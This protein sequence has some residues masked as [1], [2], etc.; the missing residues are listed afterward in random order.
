MMEGV[1]THGIKIKPEYL[2]AA[3]AGM[4]TF[5]YERD[6]DYSVGD[7][8]HLCEFTHEF[9]GAFC[10]VSVTFILRDPAYNIEYEYC[11]LGVRLL[12]F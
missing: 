2:Q 1:N 9:T 12:S 4:E 3:K 5:L 8:L 10:T 6:R 7:Q 11:V